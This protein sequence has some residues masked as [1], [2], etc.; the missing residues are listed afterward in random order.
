L[1]N[2]QGF[3]RPGSGWNTKKG[4]D[5]RVLIIVKI[6]LVAQQHI[7]WIGLFSQFKSKPATHSGNARLSIEGECHIC[8]CHIRDCGSNGWKYS[9]QIHILS[10]AHS[11]Y[12]GEFH[13]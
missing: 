3:V 11:K 5:R 2:F 13:R 7:R 4:V 10:F 1:S 6:S 12:T 9:H 8:F